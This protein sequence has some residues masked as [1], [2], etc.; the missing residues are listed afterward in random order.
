MIASDIMTRDVVSV[1]PD[2]ALSDIVALMLSH[3]ISALPVVGDGRVVGIISEGD[4][5]RRAEIGTE[6]KRS[7]WVEFFTTSDTVATDYVRSHA[8]RA[9]ELMTRDVVTVTADTPVAEVARLLESKGIKRVPVVRDGVLV[10]IVSRAN[11]VQALAG[12]LAAGGTTV[13]ADDRQ[14]REAVQ[15]EIERQS[16]SSLLVQ[17]NIT[18][19]AGVVHLW[20]TKRSEVDYRALIVAAENTPGVKQ[21]VDHVRAL[22]PILL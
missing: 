22:G 14:I 8:R 16:L 4:L 18:V 9:D 2:A 17:F 20:G 6:P 1:G 15:T 5:L 11:L 13:P 3:R 19:E 12:R 10:G 7:R 21:V